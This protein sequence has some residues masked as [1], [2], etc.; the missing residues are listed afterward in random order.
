MT[1]AR[2]SATAAKKERDLLRIAGHHAHV[3][4]LLDDFE[5]PA[6]WAL[7]LELVSGGEVFDRVATQGAFSESD[8]AA[9]VRQVALALSHLHSKE[10]VHRDLKP[11]NLLLTSK[12]EVKVADFG[13]ATFYGPK[14]PPLRISCGTI[15][16]IA[17][18]MLN[19]TSSTPYSEAVDLWSMGAILFTLLGAYNP[20]DPC[21]NLPQSTIESSIKAG[22]WDFKRFPKQWQHVSESARDVIRGLLE[23][24]VTKRLTADGL[25]AEPWVG[26]LK[27]PKRSFPKS[28]RDALQ[29]FQEGR[30]LWRAAIDAT[31]LFLGSPHMAH[32]VMSAVA[33]GDGSGR[34]KKSAAAGSVALPESADEELH[35]AFAVYDKDGNGTIDLDELR[36]V[37]QRLGGLGADAAEVMRS[38]DSDGDGILSYDEF[39]LLVRP[40]YD[41]SGAALRKIFELFDTDSSGYI[42]MAELSVMLQKLG[43]G[44]GL[45][46]KDALDRVFAAADVDGNGRV[47]FLEFTGLFPAAAASEAKE[48]APSCAAL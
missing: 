31:A 10:I 30:R 41:S 14:H 2:T 40:L 11:E 28:H 32:G 16:Y 29:A 4:C 13:L 8:A 47:D 6:A 33:A 44:K 48:A 17:P 35:R 3:A 21:S 19:V 42:D 12:D 20:F 36:G 25:L 1:K 23:L 37:M 24:D 45:E 15:N 5:T 18:E 34:K 26:G 43:L 27:T 9:V 38:I 39:K 7:V 46:T 22:R